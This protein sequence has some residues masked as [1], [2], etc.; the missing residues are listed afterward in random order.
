ME[1]EWIPLG[2]MLVLVG[3]FYVWSLYLAFKQGMEVGQRMAIA[4]QVVRQQS[5]SFKVPEGT[6]LPDAKTVSNR[7]D[8]CLECG[9][10]N[11][12]APDCRAAKP[13]PD[14]RRWMGFSRIK[15][16]LE[17]KESA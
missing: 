1:W 4:P 10:P 11:G 9:H 3:S 12:H 15:A 7:V 17:N 8:I 13:K 2:I 5:Y 14:R 16:E 6:K